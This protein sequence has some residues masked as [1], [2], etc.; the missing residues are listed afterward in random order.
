[1]K[2]IIYFLM[3]FSIL[4]VTCLG[5]VSCGEM[6]GNETIGNESSTSGFV[7]PEDVLEG[8]TPTDI[9]Y[10]KYKTNDDGTAKIT[11]VYTDIPVDKEVVVPAYI[12]EDGKKYTV[13]SIG[14]ST[15]AQS[16]IVELYI[17]YTVT[18]IG[19]SAFSHCYALTSMDFP[20]SLDTIGYNVFTDC[21]NI[22]RLVI[23][24]SVRE[25]GSQSFVDWTAEQT[26]VV[27]FREGY[28]PRGWDES[29]NDRCDA[30]I[31]YL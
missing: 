24:E 17:P 15:F 9:K 28:L 3:V 19:D 7:I 10:F 21:T 11:G 29:W 22:K 20:S 23:P 18:E 5:L 30:V 8:H 2:K 26:I 1:M 13:T 14:T 25:M 6:G 4:A 16:A 27:P 31:E 12:E